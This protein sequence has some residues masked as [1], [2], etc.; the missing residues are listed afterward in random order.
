M[1]AHNLAVSELTEDA[2][3]K[4]REAYVNAVAEEFKHLADEGSEDNN[5]VSSDKIK[6][7]SI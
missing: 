6:L 3:G 2:K 4:S 7:K 5:K 1:G